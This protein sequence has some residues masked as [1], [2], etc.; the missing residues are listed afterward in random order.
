[1]ESQS[2]ALCGVAQRQE[3]ENFDEIRTVGRVE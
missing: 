2:W 1:M 3:A